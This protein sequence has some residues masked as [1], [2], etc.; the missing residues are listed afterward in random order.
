MQGRAPAG[1]TFFPAHATD[2][3]CVPTGVSAECASAVYVCVSM[4]SFLYAF[5]QQLAGV[6]TGPLHYVLVY[7]AEATFIQAAVS[8]DCKNCVLR[9]RSMPHLLCDAGLIV[10]ESVHRS[11]APISAYAAEARFVL[12]G[13]LQ[14][15]HMLCVCMC[16]W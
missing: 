10:C 12:M 8:A 14:N 3:R 13:F 15:A 2:A 9:Q 5:D 4:A 7:A 1:C 16:P 11:V 6:H